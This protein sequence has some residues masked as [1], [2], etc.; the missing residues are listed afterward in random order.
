MMQLFSSI[1]ESRCLPAGSVRGQFQ[2]VWRALKSPSRINFS[3]L[4]RAVKYSVHLLWSMDELGV[5]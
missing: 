4:L 2:K 5:L 3:V 1:A